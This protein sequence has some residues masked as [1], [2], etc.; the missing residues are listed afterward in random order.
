MGYAAGFVRPGGRCYFFKSCQAA[1]RE[2]EEAVSTAESHALT[3]ADATKYALPSPHGQRVI[4]T[5]LK[6]LA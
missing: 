6:R 1:E 5:Y 3:C 2:R 4:L